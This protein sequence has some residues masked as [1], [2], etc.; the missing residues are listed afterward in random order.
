LVIP[1]DIVH[2]TGMT[3]AELKQEMAVL[4]CRIERC[5]WFAYFMLKRLSATHLL[6]LTFSAKMAISDII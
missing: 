4:W 3:E 2:A 5:V 6:G 1:D